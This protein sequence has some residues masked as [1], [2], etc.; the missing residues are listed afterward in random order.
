[1]G[2]KLAPTGGS[3]VTGS[4]AIQFNLV[5]SNPGKSPAYDNW[6]VVFELVGSSG[7]V[8]KTFISS[9][10]PRLFMGTGTIHETFSAAGLSGNYTVR[11]KL[12]DADGYRKFGVLQITGQNTDGS[13]T[14][15]NIA[16]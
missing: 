12:I 11:M 9:F 10:R 1:M 15:K 6:N 14:L 8:A 2:Y 13:Y 16:L 7:T 5:W 3:I 4:G